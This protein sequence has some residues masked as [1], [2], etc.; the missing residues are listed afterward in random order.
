MLHWFGKHLFWVYVLQ[1]LP[2]LALRELG[3]ADAAP[4][5]YALTCFAATVGLAW[6]MARLTAPI[7]SQLSAWS[8]TWAEYCTKREGKLSPGRGERPAP[9]P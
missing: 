6:L 9:E 4:Y 5:V 8:K 3:M 1:R 2:M 7:D